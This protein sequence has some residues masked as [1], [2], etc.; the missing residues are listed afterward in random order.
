MKY[1][2]TVYVFE[3]RNRTGRKWI[4]SSDYAP[5]S[6]KR[7]ADQAAVEISDEGLIYRAVPY[8]REKIFNPSSGLG[9]GRKK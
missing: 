2:Q 4:L 8:S 7:L 6:D 3:F 1:P 5:F 9:R